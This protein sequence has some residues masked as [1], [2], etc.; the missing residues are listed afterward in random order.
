MM[1]E[2]LRDVDASLFFALIPS[3]LSLFFHHG[4]ALQVPR[5]LTLQLIS[6][7]LIV[8]KICLQDET[9]YELT[10]YALLRGV[11]WIELVEYQDRVLVIV[12]IVGVDHGR[13]Q[14]LVFELSNGVLIDLQ[15]I[16]FDSY[17]RSAV[18]QFFDEVCILGGRM[19]RR[20]FW[21]C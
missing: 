12:D 6:L 7:C 16:D 21:P 18:I 13:G 1:P 19:Y 14:H 10:S 20:I 5:H 9:T 11:G 3:S 4:S 8:S 17:M 15:E 2:P